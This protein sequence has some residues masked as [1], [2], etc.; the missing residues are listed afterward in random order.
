M[1][2]INKKIIFWLLAVSIATAVVLAYKYPISEYGQLKKYVYQNGRV[3]SVVGD[4]VV[5]SGKIGLS[6]PNF[7]E[8]LDKTIE[9]KVTS[10]T[11]VKE[12]RFLFTEENL[13][14]KDT[15]SPKTEL[16]TG[17]L[18]NLIP[19][20]MVLSVK[21][22]QDLLQS[23]KATLAEIHILTYVLPQTSN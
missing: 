4:K 5:V 8:P 9:F 12:T 2:R 16:I 7:K 19:G 11:V 10:Q 14:S 21:S 15:Y 13:K 23:D 17:K 20:M 18:S 3:V 1:T 6:D 22:G